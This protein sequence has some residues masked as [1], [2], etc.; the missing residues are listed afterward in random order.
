MSNGK[1]MIINLKSGSIKKI[2][3]YKISY[4][5]KPCTRSKNK[6]KVELDLSNYATKPHLKNV[7]DVIYQKLI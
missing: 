4:F 6:I 2:K 3:S 1:V 7:I 5:S